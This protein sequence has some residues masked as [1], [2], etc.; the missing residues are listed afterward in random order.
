[1]PAF[2]HSDI[3]PLSDQTLWIARVSRHSWLFSYLSMFVDTARGTKTL[4]F[5]LYCTNDT[6]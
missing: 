3:S 2:L 6:L 5:F 1:M 4:S